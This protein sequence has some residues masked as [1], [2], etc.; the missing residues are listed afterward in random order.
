MDLATV[1]GVD[2]VLVLNPADAGEVA[3]VEEILVGVGKGD[4][5]AA[6]G[7]DVGDDGGGAGAEVVAGEAVVVLAQLLALAGGAEL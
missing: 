3:V 5:D 4:G 6:A 1:G 2:L 7:G